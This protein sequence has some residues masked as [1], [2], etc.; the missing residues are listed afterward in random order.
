[1]CG[2]PTWAAEDDGTDLEARYGT[3]EEVIST[4]TRR[5]EPLQ[6]TP[7]A[8]TVM[9][10]RQID[11]TFSANI[12][13]MPFL[14]PNVNISNGLLSNQATPS[15]RG[16]TLGDVD[17]TFD[18]PVATMVNGVYYSRTVMNNLDMFDVESL[19]ILRGPQGTLFGRNT[20]GG[21]LQLRTKRPV[22]EFETSGKITIGEYGRRD[23][24]AAVNVPI[25]EGRVNARVAAYSLNTG[26][27][28]NSLET[29]NSSSNDIG[30]DNKLSIRP[31]VHFIFSDTVDLTLIGEYHR[32]ES[33]IR[34]PKNYSGT[35]R[36][37]CTTFGECGT[38]FDELDDPRDDFD[39]DVVRP[40]FVD[41]EIYSITSEL[42]WDVPMGTVSWISNYRD[43]EETWV[44]DADATSVD[45]FEVDR[46]QPHE[47]YSTE[48][49]FASSGFDNFDFIGGVFYFHQEYSLER[50]TGIGSDRLAP[51]PDPNAFIIPLYSITGQEHE[52]WS[53]FG[54][55]NWHVT[56]QLTVTAGGRYTDETKD[57]F[58]QTFAVY[59]NTG[60]RQDYSESWDD[61]G[62][63]FAIKYQATDEIM[64]YASYQKGFKS[65]GFNGRC[66]Q[67]ATCARPFGPEEVDGYE[68]GLKA[69]FFDNRLRTNIAAFL[70]EIEGL[71]RGRIVPLPPGATNPQETVTDNAANATMKGIE[72]EINAYITPELRIDFMMGYLDSSYD[73]FCADINGATIE[74]TPPV[75]DCG[76]EVVGFP[77]GDGIAYIVDT[78]NSDLAFNL[79]PEFNMT[80][81]ATYEHSLTN[82]G[83]VVLN[84]NYTYVDETY[85]DIGELSLRNSVELMNA[86]ISY[87][88]PGERYRVSLYGTNL[89]DDIYVNSR[90]IVPPLFDYRNVSPPRQ[91]GVEFGWNL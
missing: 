48:L 20:T 82:G 46:D 63:K 67:T 41:I 47:Q 80:I 40:G 28:Y 78:D 57:Y 3:V 37:L 22:D 4:A 39:A 75:S 83:T 27:W 77:S 32:D 12:A 10:A 17:S 84:A 6:E 74:A 87:E 89:T 68:I 64:A 65:G 88:S 49:R 24:R 85:T 15:I 26:G 23:V 25:V 58:Q 9:T 69:D 1:M 90:T 66:G 7:V 2:P 35:N 72:L 31:T 11:M 51:V 86:S 13:A 36:T 59:P 8:S 18:P 30:K 34:P 14:A 45:M 5:A 55:V 54:E 50:R 21:A 91:W 29:A 42:N 44:Y 71:Q 79:A 56:D 33:D 43:T 52:A 60:P 16:Y 38:P 19:E 73:E 70:T 76:G 62:P 81:A 53:V 61:A